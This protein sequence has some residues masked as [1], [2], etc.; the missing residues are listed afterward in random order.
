[1]SSMDSKEK[2]ERNLKILRL[3]RSGYTARQIAEAFG[4]SPRHVQ[5]ITAEMRVQH[6]EWI[7]RLARG[8]EPSALGRD[9]ALEALESLKQSMDL[10]VKILN[11]RER[12][13]R[14]AV[15][16]EISKRVFHNS[17]AEIEAALMLVPERPS[18]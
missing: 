9:R 14:G 1:M 11:A 4:L 15:G 17:Y 8:D 3:S 16:G 6:R 2:H 5:R 7:Q 13:F 10:M 12:D 18:E